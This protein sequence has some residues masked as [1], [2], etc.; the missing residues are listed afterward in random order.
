LELDAVLLARVLEVFPP[1]QTF[2][3]CDKGM[4]NTERQGLVA[5]VMHFVTLELCCLAEL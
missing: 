2:E 1:T 3:N 5:S 4:S